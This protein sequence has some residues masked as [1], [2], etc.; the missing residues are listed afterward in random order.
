[1]KFKLLFR[2]KPTRKTATERKIDRID[3]KITNLKMHQKYIEK[4][5]P[6]KEPPVVYER[7]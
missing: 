6:K 1:M 2:D 7:V 4:F 3:R 5:V